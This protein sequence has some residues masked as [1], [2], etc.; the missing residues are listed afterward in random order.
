M[1]SAAIPTRYSARTSLLRIEN[2]SAGCGRISIIRDISFEIKKGE[3][4]SVI[5]RNGV[6]KSTLMKT[7]MGLNRGF[8]GKIFFKEI[9]R[10]QFKRFRIFRT[11]VHD[12]RR[13][14]KYPFPAS[15]RS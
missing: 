15:A 11:F 5:G 7:L 14:E 13:D 9:F 1:A 12:H 6:G 8:G 3:I 10:R 4:V 2:L